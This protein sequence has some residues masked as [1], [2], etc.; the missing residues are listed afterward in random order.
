MFISFFFSSTNT[1]Q[2]MDKI[3]QLR[4]K[5]RNTERL[6]IRIEVK[7][8]MIKHQIK[9]QLRREIMKQMRKPTYVKAIVQ[10]TTREVLQYM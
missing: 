3:A 10:Q 8:Q 9:L 4:R 6:L 1:K 7:R 5:K 2:K